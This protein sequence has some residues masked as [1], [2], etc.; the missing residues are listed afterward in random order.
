[1]LSE[2][3]TDRSPRLMLEASLWM[4]RSA[5]G[6]RNFCSDVCIA[7]RQS[8]SA[9]TRSLIYPVSVQ[10]LAACGLR[11]AHSRDRAASTSRGAARA[12]PTGA[13]EPLTEYAPVRA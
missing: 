6:P 10:L 8:R 2:S 5:S 3:P 13:C 7:R 1:M 11:H 9:R 4:R 12:V